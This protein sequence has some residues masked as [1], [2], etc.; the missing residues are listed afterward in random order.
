MSSLAT[1]RYDT[2]NLS[3]R[4]V[5]ESRNVLTGS[6]PATTVTVS[7]APGSVTEIS[8][9]RTSQTRLTV[10]TPPSHYRHPGL[11]QTS[12]VVSA[13]SGC[14]NVPPSSAFPTGGNVTESLTVTIP[15]T[16]LAV[17]TTLPAPS[18]MTLS[19]SLTPPWRDVRITSSS[20]TT[21]TVSGLT[22][23]VTTARTAQEGRMRTP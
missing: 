9:V 19:Q 1:A 2:I 11:S 7:T 3:L 6:S 20:V 22:G 15:V 23:S 8:T 4:A 5:L 21:E 10:L 12:R 18:L 17:V 13:T 16:S 14:S